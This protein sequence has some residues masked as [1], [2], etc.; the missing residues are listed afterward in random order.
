MWTE[1]PE[2]NA[3]V[4]ACDGIPTDAL[5]ALNRAIYAFLLDAEVAVS[6]EGDEARGGVL[7]AL[8]DITQALSDVVEGEVL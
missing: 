7:D 1:S 3:L 5:S 4:D 2:L 8:D 6:G